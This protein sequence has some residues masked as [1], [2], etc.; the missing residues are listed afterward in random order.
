MYGSAVELCNTF[1]DRQ[2]NAGPARL[3]IARA[4]VT[5][6]DLSQTQS[7]NTLFIY[8]RPLIAWLNPRKSDRK[9]C[10]RAEVEGHA[11]TLCL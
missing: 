1:G 7:V 11:P 8:L 9:T 5:D 2:T 3:P 6:P 4:I 10:A